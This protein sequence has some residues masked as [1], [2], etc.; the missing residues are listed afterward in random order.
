[1]ESRQD[2]PAPAQAAP[3]AERPAVH[4]PIPAPQLELVPAQTVPAQTVPAQAVTA[5]V[6]PEQV[7]PAQASA[8][9]EETVVLPAADAATIADFAEAAA[10]RKAFWVEIHEP[11]IVEQ[12]V[13]ETPAVVVS[14]ETVVAEPIPEPVVVAS[15]GF[16][17][18]AERT[19]SMAASRLSGLRTLMTSLG[20]KNLHKELELRKTHLELTPVVERPIE[21]PVYAQPETLV[22]VSEGTIEM[23]IREVMALPE[24]IPPRNAMEHVERES[25]LRRPVKSTRVSRWES[26]DDV[27]TLPSKRGQYRKRH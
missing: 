27:E 13:A 14:E 19:G 9:A 21:R 25:E 22:A 24:I 5:Q 6:I 17:P 1:V 7:V 20:V 3:E 10:A 8:T 2:A 11:S 12:P 4:E 23:P 16:E 18:E 26:M 15:V